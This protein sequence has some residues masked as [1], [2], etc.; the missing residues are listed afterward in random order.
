[1]LG[2]DEDEETQEY[3][4]LFIVDKEEIISELIISNETEN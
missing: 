4:E 1:M 2:F 3:V